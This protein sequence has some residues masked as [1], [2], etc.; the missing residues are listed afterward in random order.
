MTPFLSK[1]SLLL[2]FLLL[3][4]GFYR[5]TY[6][7]SKFFLAL[8]LFWSIYSNGP[9]KTVVDIIWKVSD[10]SQLLVVL[11]CSFHLTLHYVWFHECNV[12]LTMELNPSK[13][14]E[15]KLTNINGFYKFNIR[16]KSKKLIFTLD[17]LNSKCYKR[18]T[19]N[20][21]L[22]RSNLSEEIHP[23][24]EKADYSLCFINRV[25]TQKIHKLT[26]VITVSELRQHRKLKKYDLHFS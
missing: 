13:F 25:F 8:A 21:D 3:R 22:D 15:T 19:K 12:K 11:L 1:T 23:I 17:C 2:S 20:G 7:A 10:G 24:K 4:S 18:N 5:V 14:L 9:C 16:W 6:D 26:T